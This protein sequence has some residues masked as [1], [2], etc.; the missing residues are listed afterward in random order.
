MSIKRT[1]QR[2]YGSSRESGPESSPFGSK[3]VDPVKTWQE[4]LEGKPD[5]SFVAYAFA[6]RF[7]KGALLAHP[8][9]GKGVVVGVEPQRIEVL[10]EEGLKK[11]G[12]GGS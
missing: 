2:T 10:F 11:L 6:A 12:H 5:E 9:F 7:E 4:Q 3:P 1:K 8:K